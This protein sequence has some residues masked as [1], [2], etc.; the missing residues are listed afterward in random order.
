VQVRKKLLTFEE[1]D[2]SDGDL[3]TRHITSVQSGEKKKMT[4]KCRGNGGKETVE[5][6]V[7]N[8]S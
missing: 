8:P 4:A 7:D 1:R 6:P 5:N 2:A 3:K